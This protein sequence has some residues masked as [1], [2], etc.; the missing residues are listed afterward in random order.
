MT[1]QASTEP[2][3]PTQ[4]APRPGGRRWIAAGAGVVVIAVGMGF[5]RSRASSHAGAAPASSA[6]AR[7][8]PVSTASVEK[9]DVPVYLEGLGNAL[10][11]ATVTVKSQVDGRLDKVVFQEGQDVHKGDLLA[12][13]DPRPFAIQLHTAE[14]AMLR[15]SAQLRNVKLN[16]SRFHELKERNLIAEQQVDDQQ[17]LADQ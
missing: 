17:A 1:A 9:R 10:P 6:E 8:V 15:D 13:V 12:Q 3:E 4:A 5:W 16:L 7:I 11:L 2:N 14:A